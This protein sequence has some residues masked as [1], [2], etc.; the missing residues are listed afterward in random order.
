MVEEHGSPFF[1][2]KVGVR[3][4][5]TEVA[6]VEEVRAAIGEDALLRLDANMRWSVAVADG[7]ALIR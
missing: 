7:R 2:G 3:D 1:E 4:L 6:M 5:V